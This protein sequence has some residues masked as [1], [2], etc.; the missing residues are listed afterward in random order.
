[1]PSLEQLAPTL[2]IPWVHAALAGLG[3]LALVRDRTLAFAHGNPAPV[4]PAS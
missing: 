4:R 2:A 3:R 1:M